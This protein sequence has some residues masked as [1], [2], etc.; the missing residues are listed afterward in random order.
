VLPAIDLYIMKNKLY[1]IILLLCSLLSACDDKRCTSIDNR[2][3]E[4]LNTQYNITSWALNEPAN[5]VVFSGVRYS[6]SWQES[7]GLFMYNITSKQEVELLQGIFNLEKMWVD[8][9]NQDCYFVNI[10]RGG[11][12]HFSISRISLGTK[13][14]QILVDSVVPYSLVYSGHLM[15]YNKS[16]PST[17]GLDLYVYDAGTGQEKRIGQGEPKGISA[18]TGEL[19]YENRASS[20]VLGVVTNINNGASWL[21]NEQYL[22]Y[23]N[24]EFFWKNGELFVLAYV[25][26][27]GSSNDEIKIFNVSRNSQVFTH[28]EQAKWMATRY[29]VSPAGTHV[30]YIASFE[31]QGPCPDQAFIIKTMQIDSKENNEVAYGYTSNSF[32]PQEIKFSEDGEYLY[33][34]GHT[35]MYRA[36]RQ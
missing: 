28:R 21:I 15:A 19:V 14:V 6:A 16:T 24:K 17:Q 33:H 13:Q 30:A 36:R 34:A 1:I 4:L 3:E 27:P 26:P 25:S 11:G 35:G 23:Q 12:G 18:S 32:Y 31:Q 22:Q 9:A 10:A 20:R 2:G 8:K 29:F 7:H 5:T